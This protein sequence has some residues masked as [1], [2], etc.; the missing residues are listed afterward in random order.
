MLDNNHTTSSLT[1]CLHTINIS[2]VWGIITNNSLYSRIATISNNNSRCS[3]IIMHKVWIKTIKTV[4]QANLL[5][6][7]FQAK[8]STKILNS[9]RC[10]WHKIEKVQ[11]HQDFLLKRLINP[12]IINFHLK[13]PTPTPIS[14]APPKPILINRISK[15][16]NNQ[17]TI[18]ETV[19]TITT[20]K[21]TIN[22]HRKLFKIP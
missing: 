5:T 3:I 17:K 4:M 20:Q 7:K 19:K 6:Q 12:I 9:T 14:K 15:I 1:S 11:I 2:K 18:I 22:H 16:Y 8:L 10:N 13:R 21:N